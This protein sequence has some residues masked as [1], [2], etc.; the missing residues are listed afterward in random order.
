MQ[1]D[2]NSKN[3]KASKIA[4][5]FYCLQ[6]TLEQFHA[7][8]IKDIKAKNIKANAR[9]KDIPKI[10]EQNVDLA[11]KTWFKTGGPARFFAQPTTSLELSQAINFAY[12]NKLNLF[13]LG[14]GANVLISDDGFN[15]LVISMQNKSIELVNKTQNKDKDLAHVKAGAGVIFQDLINWC[16]NNNI[17]G[18]EEFSGI[19]G[20]VGGSVY[21][22]IHY[23]EFL[24]SNFLISAE[25]VH[26]ETGELIIVDK[27]WFNFGYNQSKLQEK[28]YFL[29]NATFELKIC[30]AGEAEFH[31]G[32]T[33]EIIRHRYKKYPHTNTCGSF[34]RNFY[35]HEVRLESLGKKLIFVAYYLEQVGVKGS[36]I[37]GGASVSYQH[38]NMIV[39]QNNAT[40]TDIIN[41]ARLMQKKVYDRFKILP[42]PECQLIGFKKYPLLKK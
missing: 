31:K 24:L 36:L 21:I 20:T 37:F 41:L 25:V 10:I 27:A 33:A 39:N 26:K 3:T 28:E 9:I 19:P 30:T 38:A 22:N 8:N 32:R 34:F 29:V 14:Q 11:D 35:E 6:K 5:A 2:K 18:L 16:L 12:K 4:E 1:K 42:Q 17:T 40:S 13:F 7:Q 15:G 23:F